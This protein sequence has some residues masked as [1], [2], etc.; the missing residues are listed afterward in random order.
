MCCRKR[1]SRVPQI[2][3][4]RRQSALGFGVLPL[5]RLRNGHLHILEYLVERE[6]DQ[7]HETAC[8]YAAENGHL[9]CLKYLHETAK[10]PWD[11]AP[12]AT[13]TRTTTPSVYNTSSTTTVLSQPVGLTKEE[14]YTPHKHTHTQRE[15]R[16]ERKKERETQNQAYK[17]ETRNAA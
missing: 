2:L 8:W 11:G 12:Y 17:K 5:G 9:D 7:Y 16:K 4:R 14:L 1:S 6:F 15:R 10:A 3:T 13:R